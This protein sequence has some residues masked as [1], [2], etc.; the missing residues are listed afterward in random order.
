[1][2]VRGAGLAFR[3]HAVDPFS[4][5]V[6]P[7]EV[8]MQLQS[9]ERVCSLRRSTHLASAVVVADP[10]KEMVSHLPTGVKDVADVQF[11]LTHGV[12]YRGTARTWK[13]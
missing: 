1:M 2:N 4:G 7:V 5:V 8:L 10:D 3:G 12:R 6:P 13:K 11:M 9:A